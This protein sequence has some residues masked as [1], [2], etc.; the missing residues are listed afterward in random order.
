[1]NACESKQ[2]HLDQSTGIII[3]QALVSNNVSS[4][5][6]EGRASLWDALKSLFHLFILSPPSR[7]FSTHKHAH[8]LLPCLSPSV[9]MTQ[10]EA[11]PCSQPCRPHRMRLSWE[12][13]NLGCPI[14]PLYHFNGCYLPSSEG[15]SCWSGP[16]MKRGIGRG[17]GGY[18]WVGRGIKPNPYRGK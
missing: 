11:G 12:V 8:T 3:C 4:Q 9:G 17:G 16:R 13:I 5:L 18:G 15:L 7:H 10:E 6:E 1:M 14:I 2:L